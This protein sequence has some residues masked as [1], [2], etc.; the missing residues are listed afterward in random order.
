VIGAFLHIPSAE[1][2]RCDIWRDMPD[3]QRRT[4]REALAAAGIS[5]VTTATSIR[6]RS[7]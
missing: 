5:H 2:R 3:E 4:E 6:R 7:P 1:G